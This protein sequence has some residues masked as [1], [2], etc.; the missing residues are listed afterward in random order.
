MSKEHTVHDQTEGDSE[1][2]SRGGWGYVHEA[3]Q[4]MQKLRDSLMSA[5]AF[6]HTPDSGRPLVL[7]KLWQGAIAAKSIK[8]SVVDALAW[9][10]PF[11]PTWM[12]GGLCKSVN[13]GACGP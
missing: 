11:E 3:S 7:G 4:V 10:G 6:L 8:F 13:I 5:P 2:R 12:L 1:T 9:A